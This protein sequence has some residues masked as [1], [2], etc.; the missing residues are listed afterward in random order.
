MKYLVLLIF[1]VGCTEVA[2]EQVPN[3]TDEPIAPPA[4]L[5]QGT[6]LG[7]GGPIGLDCLDAVW[8]DGVVY[9]EMQ[10]NLG[11]DIKV[12]KLT[13]YDDEEP[14]S[15]ITFCKTSQNLSIDVAQ[16]GKFILQI[17]CS[18]FDRLDQGFEI[19]Y[20]GI[21]KYIGIKSK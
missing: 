20:N 16:E 2:V 8:K 17:D 7:C 11:Y 15:T 19:T 14:W 9:A 1:L 6:E 4:K 5:P 3:A 10:N 13:Q 21:K 12:T 18:G